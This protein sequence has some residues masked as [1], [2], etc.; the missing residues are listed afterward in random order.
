MTNRR[1]SIGCYIPRAAAVALAIG[2]AAGARSEPVTLAL[3]ASASSGYA[4][5]LFRLSPVEQRLG[6]FASIDDVVFTPRLGG[7]LRAPVGRQVIEL[8]GSAAYRFHRSNRQVDAFDYDF[9]GRLIYALGSVCTGTLSA[10]QESREADYADLNAGAPLRFTVRDRAAAGDIACAITPS[11]GTAASFEYRTQANSRTP[12]AIYDLDRT[13]IYAEANA[14]LRDTGQWFAAGRY[15]RREQP[16]FV[17]PATPDG[18]RGEIW[19]AGGGVRWTPGSDIDL[20][21]EAYWTR[22]RETSGRRNSTG[23]SAA[24]KAVY[25]LSPKTSI[26]LGADTG[27]D[28][29]SNI[30][31]VAFRA[32][33]VGLDVAWAAT[34][35]IDV[36]VHAGHVWR[37]ILRAFGPGAAGGVVRQENDRTL[38]LGGSLVYRLTDRLGARLAAAYRDRRGNFEDITF[39]ATTVT[40]GLTYRFEGPPLDAALP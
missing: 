10:S 20:S 12:L 38:D 26:T 2:A 24:A 22:L 6:G 15:R 19:D 35:K 29:S 30:G 40:F 18:L 39:R 21:A 7:S 32:T 36:T 34:P 37:G 14:G 1:R 8:K 17:F 13:T 16:L 11:I 9:D 31:A 33:S 25:A 5:N 23:L 28:V 27:L 4:S 3:N